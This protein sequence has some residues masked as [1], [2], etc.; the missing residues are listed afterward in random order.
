MR[1]GLIPMPDLILCSLSE[2][3]NMPVECKLH[4]FFNLDG[5]ACL[6]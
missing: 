4:P 2:P 3:D 1:H 6:L 5:I